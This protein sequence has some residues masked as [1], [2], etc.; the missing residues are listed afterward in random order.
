M[1]Q[2]EIIKNMGIDRMARVIV[3][4]GSP[5]ICALILCPFHSCKECS[6]QTTDTCAY[7]VRQWLESE[8]KE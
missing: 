5:Y 8:V 2:Y 7:Y 4:Y 3:E 1:T 6:M